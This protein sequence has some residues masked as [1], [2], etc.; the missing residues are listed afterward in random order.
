MSMNCLSFTLI[1]VYFT[2]LGR[3]KSTV[4]FYIYISS[5][6]ERLYPNTRGPH[7]LRAILECI[8]F[9]HERLCMCVSCW[10]R[11]CSGHT[12]RFSPID[13]PHTHTSDTRVHNTPVCIWNHTYTY[14]WASIHVEPIVRASVQRTYHTYTTL[15]Y[16]TCA[17]VYAWF[18]QPDEITKRFTCNIKSLGPSAIGFSLC[19]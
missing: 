19:R 6:N 16:D 17:C 5:A 18:I 12:S 2:I 8:S 13:H 7:I 10:H 9:L 1:T 14:V 3:N 11:T 4:W 15:H